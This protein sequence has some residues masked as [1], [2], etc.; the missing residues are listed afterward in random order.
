MMP[1]LAMELQRIYDS[2]INTR[3]FWFWDSGFTIQLGDQMN[4]YLA[5]ET[6]AS[7]AE[8]LALAPTGDCA[9]LPRLHL[10]PRS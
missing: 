2:E 9:L 1:D 5:V 10:H 6:V 4:G 7:A 3:I 8:I